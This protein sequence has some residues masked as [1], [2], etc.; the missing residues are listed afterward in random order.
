VPGAAPAPPRAPRLRRAGRRAR[1]AP[2]ST[3]SRTATTD[4][5]ISPPPRRGR[6]ASR[7][8]GG[9]PCIA[10]ERAAALRCAAVRPGAARISTPPLIRVLRARALQQESSAKRG[11]ARA[12]RHL[13]GGQRS[14]QQPVRRAAVVRPARMLSCF[15]ALCS[16]KPAALARRLQHTNAKKQ[17]RGVKAGTQPRGQQSTATTNAGRAKQ[18]A[19]V[20]A[21][22]WLVAALLEFGAVSTPGDCGRRA[23]RLAA[24]CAWAYGG[25]SAS[26]GECW[27]PSC[28]VTCSA[29]AFG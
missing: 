6:L 13:G 29:A 17:M 4:R 24:L 8:G 16:A 10:R 22:A 27:E 3:L 1:A 9:I 26:A 14:L 7:Q 23:G 28:S 15:T 11:V 20:V 25:T 18:D 19:D 12:L 21:G 5:K 2:R